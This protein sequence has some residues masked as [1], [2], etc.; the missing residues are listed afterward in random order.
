MNVDVPEYVPAF[1]RIQGFL[2]ICKEHNIPHELLLKDL[3]NTYDEN[4]SAIQDIADYLNSKYTG[5][6]KGI[7]LSN[8]TYANIFLNYL[9]RIYGSMPDDYC[10]VGFDN[11]PISTEAVIPTSTVGQ[12]IDV[13]AKTA[14]EILV[15][16]M[17]ERKKRRPTFLSEPIHKTITPILINRETTFLPKK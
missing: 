2:D 16:Q 9:I 7:F 13:I 12:Q 11:S 6:R 8:D 14:M 10:I 5:K 3:G 4:K 1:G 17:T 15:E